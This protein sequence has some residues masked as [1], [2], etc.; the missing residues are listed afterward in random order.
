MNINTNMDLI[1]AYTDSN[2]LQ[3][4]SELN[5]LDDLMKS[6]KWFNINYDKNTKKYTIEKEGDEEEFDS[7]EEGINWAHSKYVEYNLIP[8]SMEGWKWNDSVWESE[9]HNVSVYAYEGID[10]NIVYQFN[11]AINKESLEGFKRLIS[12][13]KKLLPPGSKNE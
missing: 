3:I 5:K 10:E 9:T 13:N 11:G 6:C 8:E 12:F 7:L 4:K 1:T 2:F